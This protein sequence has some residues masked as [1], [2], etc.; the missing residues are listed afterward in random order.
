MALALVEFN[1]DGHGRP[2]NE[3]AVARLD[4][5]EQLPERH[6]YT[7]QVDKTEHWVVVRPL[8]LV[9]LPRT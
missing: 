3:D 6:R 4:L 7:G 1:A 2:R 9:A 8:E 5:L